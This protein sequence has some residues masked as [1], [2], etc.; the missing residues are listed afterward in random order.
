MIVVLLSSLL[1]VT[2]KYPLCFDLGNSKIISFALRVTRLVDQTLRL[3][4]ADTLMEAQFKV[5]NLQLNPSCGLNEAAIL[6]LID[7]PGNT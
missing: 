4:I 2:K 6:R 3:S 7:Q 1:L 5:S